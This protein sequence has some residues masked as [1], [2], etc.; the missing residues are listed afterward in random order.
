[1]PQLENTAIGVIKNVDTGK[2]LGL[3][4]VDSVI[5]TFSG[6]DCAQTALDE[7]SKSY[8]NDEYDIYQKVQRTFTEVITT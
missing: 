3:Y 7:I 1:M 8:G 4:K 5:K 6:T 2:E